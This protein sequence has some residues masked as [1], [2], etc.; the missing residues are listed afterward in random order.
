ME[1]Y[2]ILCKSKFKFIYQQG[3]QTIYSTI[4]Y[5]SLVKVYNFLN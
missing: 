3:I 5:R 2:T 1:K 4:K